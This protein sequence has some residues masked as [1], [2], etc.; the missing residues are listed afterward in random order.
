M[1]VHQQPP[2][3]TEPGDVRDGATNT[4]HPPPTAKLLAVAVDDT[5]LTRSELTQLVE[6]RVQVQLV[7]V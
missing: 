6:L 1:A 2:A 4:S 3:F 5:R 7:V